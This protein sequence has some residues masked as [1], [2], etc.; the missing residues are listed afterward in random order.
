M[1]SAMPFPIFIS[2]TDSGHIFADNV[3]Q[4]MKETVQRSM[5]KVRTEYSMDFILVFEKYVEYL[6]SEYKKDGTRIDSGE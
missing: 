5:E 1:A 2:L 3:T 6:E 4:K